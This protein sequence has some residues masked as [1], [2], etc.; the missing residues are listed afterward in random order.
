MKSNFAVFI[1][2]NLFLLACQNSNQKNAQESEKPQNA[3]PITFTER[4]DDTVNKEIEKAKTQP[5][6]SILLGFELGMNEEEYKLRFDELIKQSILKPLVEFEENSKF[7]SLSADTTGFFYPLEIENEFYPLHFVPTFKGKKLS[8]ISAKI[9]TKL[10]DKK[11]E[12]LYENLVELYTKKYGDD[13]LEKVNMYKPNDFI[14]IDSNRHI[15]LLVS[16]S[17]IQIDYSD[18]M[19]MNINLAKGEKKKEENKSSSLDDI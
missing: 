4:Y 15:N 14:W 13:Y 19:K 5:K 9:E 6:N 3:V 18:I 10:G 7:V 16:F 1:I 8:S 2:C 12:T 17:S 11:T